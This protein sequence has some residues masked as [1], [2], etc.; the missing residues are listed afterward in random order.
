MSWLTSFICLSPIPV[1][2][3][4][5]L[6]LFCHLLSI[7]TFYICTL[8]RHFFYLASTDTG[9]FYPPFITLSS[10]STVN[11]PIFLYFPSTLLVSTLR[12][13][14]P[15]TPTP[16]FHFCR[17]LLLST[18]NQRILHMSRDMRFPIMWYVR[19][20]KAQTSLRIRAV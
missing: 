7:K 9:Y 3:T 8:H 18:L 17:P 6:H 14:I 16:H 12:T 1:T 5:H 4:L 11:Q 15:V 10:T 20:A 2:S 13:P 19:P